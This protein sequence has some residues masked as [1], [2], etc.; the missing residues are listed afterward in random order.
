MAQKIYIL[1]IPWLNRT[2]DLLFFCPKNVVAVLYIV[3]QK[4]RFEIFIWTM[5]V[6]RG[7]YTYKNSVTFVISYRT[8]M[9]FKENVTPQHILITQTNQNLH[10]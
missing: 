2:L 10:T 4:H 3:R 8:I 5:M 6:K 1:R 9:H 7:E